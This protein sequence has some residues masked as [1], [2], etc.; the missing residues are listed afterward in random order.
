MSYFC[1]WRR[2][3][4]V[5]RSAILESDSSS[6]RHSRATNTRGNVADATFAERSRCFSSK[7]VSGQQPELASFYSTGDER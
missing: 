6:P 4:Q 2:E 3:A 7:S 5:L 1:Y